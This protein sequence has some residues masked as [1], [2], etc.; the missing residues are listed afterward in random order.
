MDVLPKRFGS[1][2][3]SLHP[4]K[5]AI[6]PFG[7]PSASTHKN[8]RNGTFDFLGFTFYWA[9]S[10]KGYWVIKKKIAGKR[11][12]RFM[13]MVWQWTRAYRH[14]P[15]WEQYL[16]LSSKLRGFYQYYGVITN[17]KALETVYE[18]VYEYAEKAWRYWLSK[19]SQRHKVRMA[20]LRSKYPLPKPRIVHNI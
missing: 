13:K 15:A 6:I 16:I 5:T 3:L 12:N 7:R 10:L 2:D 20:D 1:Y 9:R 8:K 19:R 14:D 4:T 17:Y 18:T 11:I